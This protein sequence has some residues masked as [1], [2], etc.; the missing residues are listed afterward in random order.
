MWDAAQSIVIVAIRGE[1]GSYNL[2][3]VDL[4]ERS[5][6]A[7]RGERGSYNSRSDIARHGR[8]L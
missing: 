8:E 1:R 5:I 2:E 4:A 6:V 3:E 7:I